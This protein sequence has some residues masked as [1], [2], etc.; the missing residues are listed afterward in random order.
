MLKSILLTTLRNF[1]RNFS[2]SSINLV[3][4]SVSMSL[5]LL[6][7][8]VIKEQFTFDNFHKDADRIY[9]VNTRALRTSGGSEDYASVPMPVGRVLKEEYTFA[10]E[11]VRI[12]RQ[13]RTDIVYGNVNV[14]LSGLFADP[15]FLQVF[16]FTLEKGNP[17]TALTDANG[18][19]LTHETAVRVFGDSEPLGQTVTLNGFG[20]F[21]ITGVLKKLASKT[22]F[23]FQALASSALLPLL[24]NQGVMQPSL[25]DWNNYYFGYV[26]L[27]L[28]EGRN[29]EEVGDAL[30]AISKK[31]YANLKLETRD[32]GYEFYLQPLQKITPGPAL[33]N[34]MG[35]GMPDL[36]IVFLGVL[37]GVVMLMAC[38][39]YTN[40]MI[41]KSLSRARE[42]GVR[43]IVGAQ[44]FQVFAQFVGEA[45]VFSLM[46]LVVAYGLLQ[47]LKP[48]FMQ[49]NIAREF[50]PDLREDYTVYLWFFAFA[51]FIG[52]LAGLLPAGYLSAFK[53][54][55][56]LKESGSLK[57]YSRVTF[58]KA[59]IVTQ[60]SLSLIF[61]IVV[62]VIYN[63]IDFMLSKD[64]GMN[65][66]DILNVRLQGVPYQKLATEVAKLPGVVSVGGVSHQ[67]G[68]WA[69][70]ASDYRRNQDEEAFVMRDFIV[71]ENYVRNLDMTF[72]AGNNFD[73][74]HEGAYE[75]HVILN[76]KAL[77]LFQFSDPVA[78]IGQTIFADD[79]LQLRVIGVVKNFHFRPLNYEI[80]PLALRYNYN[81]IGFLSARLVPGQREAVMA[82]T[83]GIWKKVDPVHPFDAV[84]MDEAIDN[85]YTDAGFK[86]V[87]KIV[88]YV[89]FLAVM[90]A[91]LGMLGMAMYATQTR[92]KEIGVRKVMGAS[93]QQITLLLSRSFM[94]LIGIAIAI[95]TP[96]GYFL[97]NSFLDTYAYKITVSAALLSGGILLIVVLGLITIGSQ[98]WKAASV[99]PVDILHY[100]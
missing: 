23:E 3:G 58:R 11:V 25:D 16:N 53:P 17:A 24:E 63:Q 10:E 22:H 69:D 18:L 46:A 35:N 26:Y 99:N 94:M 68:T 92:M 45:I 42:I 64:Y 80:G 43:K 62:L 56:V 79:S 30:A 50:S 39:N 47:L 70:R 48:A 95:G 71:D 67:L 73:P 36:L 72:L 20:E 19:V 55:K 6:V 83:E 33:S 13:L 77:P 100:E 44:R 93:S 32:R 91:C 7:I 1:T 81:E 12:N 85:A 66:K 2:F 15:S 75:R 27:K 54:V 82:A 14:P 34:N 84:M 40:L 28:K 37:V 88:G 49:L 8:I 61:V 31:Y 9:R 52:M 5:G 60:F 89:C 78:A 97:G 90:L 41:A 4:L 65:D 38:F 74:Q 98:T 86:D 21:K 57:V 59:L 96:V 87:L 76:E 51:V 29:T